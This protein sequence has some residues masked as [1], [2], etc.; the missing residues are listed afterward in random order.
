MKCPVSM[1]PIA[2]KSPSSVLF[3]LGAIFVI[4]LVLTTKNKSKATKN[5]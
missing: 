4:G 5:A 1:L 3:V 2:G